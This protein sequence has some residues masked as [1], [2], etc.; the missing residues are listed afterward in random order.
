MAAVTHSVTAYSLPGSVLGTGESKINQTGA[1]SELKELS[2][3]QGRETLTRNDTVI[4]TGTVQHSSLEQGLWGLTARVQIPTL[5][6]DGC[7][8]LDN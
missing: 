5:L 3:Y 4:T 7:V 8:T 6:P 1:I 2:T